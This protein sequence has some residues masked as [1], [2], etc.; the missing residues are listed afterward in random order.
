MV[1]LRLVFSLIFVLSIFGSPSAAFSEQI[2]S[3]TTIGADFRYRHELIDAEGKD[4]RNR[5]RIRARVNISTVLNDEVKLGFQLA[6]GSADPVSSNQTLDGGFSS[7]QIN[8]DLAFF[9]WKPAILSGV[10]V[11]G[12]KVKNPFYSPGKTELLWDG[13]LRPEGIVLKYS[14]SNDTASFFVNTSY[15][16]IDERKA[17]NDAV[18]IGGQ[19]GV[20]YDTSVS[21]FV[22]GVGYYDYQNTKKSA[23]FYNANDGNG[24][25]VDASGNYL[26][27]YNDVEVF[28]VITPG[29]VDNVSVFCDYVTN[30]AE[31]V[32]D[33][34]G[35]LTGFSV[36]KC[37]DPGSFDFAYS[38]RNVEKDAVIG[39]FTDSDFIGGGTD[40]EGHE[41][42]IN[43]QLASKSKISAS[44]FFNQAG[45]VNGKDYHRLQ[46]DINFKL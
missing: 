15:F 4:M 25:S 21:R 20:D 11:S 18:F 30:V 43:Y 38:F 36:G 12:G 39:A 44:Y 22:A 1:S 2:G 27:D 16:W 19:A 10:A 9:E 34:Q 17:D 42:N 29:F 5:Q 45:I 23:T 41:V 35:W 6:S 37:K 40:G 3:S 33:N 31:D 7:K 46:L 13:D 8:L 26:Y 28:C 24:N 32:D 14:K